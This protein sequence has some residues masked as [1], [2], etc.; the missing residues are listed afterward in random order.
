LA[1]A[2]VLLAGCGPTDSTSSSP[3]GSTTGAAATTTAADATTEAAKAVPELVG[4]G[5]QSAQD[6]A[7]AAG[8]YNLTS[9]DSA[10]RGRMQILDRDWKVCSQ[11]PDAGASEATSVAIDLGA[12][13]LAETC[14]AT[15]QAPP[16]DAGSTMPNFVGKGLNTARDS[17]PSATSITSSDAS[18]QGRFIILES[19]WKVCT[20]DPAPGVALSGQPVTFTAV[21]FGE[22]C[23]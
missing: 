16:A 2:G 21:K 6:A 11:T 15:D 9:H 17:L 22:P 12:V 23:P 19:N 4:M 13:K 10:G 3:A 20:Q 18:D 14:P 1:A 5:L 7:Q 8:F